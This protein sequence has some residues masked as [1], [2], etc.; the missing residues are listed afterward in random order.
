MD[1]RLAIRRLLAD[2]ESDRQSHADEVSLY[3]AP[4]FLGEGQAAVALSFSV[5]FLRMPV[6]EGTGALDDG[7]TWDPTNLPTWN[8]GVLVWEKDERA[9]FTGVLL[10]CVARNTGGP[11]TFSIHVSGPALRNG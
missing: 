2:E 9:F 10:S 4:R 7:A 8:V 1:P 3:A 6:I 5:R 11:S